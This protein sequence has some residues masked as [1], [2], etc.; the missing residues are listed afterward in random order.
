VKGLLV[1]WF[2]VA[3]LTASC[4]GGSSET[5]TVAPTALRSLLETPSAA[6]ASRQP[7]GASGNQRY[8]S[9]TIPPDRLQES[10]RAASDL[11]RPWLEDG[12]I[13]FAE[14]EQY[15]FAKMACLE[16]GGLTVAH[17]ITFGRGGE[18]IPG[19]LLTKRGEYQFHAVGARGAPYNE[20]KAASVRCQN[21]AP[22]VQFFWQAVHTQPT[23][24]EFQEHRKAIAACIRESGHNAPEIPTVDELRKI[25]FPPDGYGVWDDG[26]EWF[27]SCL[28]AANDEFQI[29]QP[30]D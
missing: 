19:P 12:V 25:E 9:F 11:E 22:I 13:T 24:K 1:L 30:V 4:A 18:S 15:A 8:G 5:S 7:L 23:E 21:L 14:Y 3:L 28:W 26:P 2:A 17:M 16:E 10:L 27:V 20:V 6:A 29:Y